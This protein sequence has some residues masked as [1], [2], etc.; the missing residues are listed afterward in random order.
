ME[1]H[2]PFAFFADQ[3]L[4]GAYQSVAHFVAHWLVDDVV[5]LYIGSHVQPNAIAVS[6]AIPLQNIYYD[7]S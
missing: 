2:F 6:V 4:V 1:I 3:Q 5:L 7:I